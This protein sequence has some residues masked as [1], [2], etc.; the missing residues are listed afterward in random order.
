MRSPAYTLGYGLTIVIAGVLLG[1][2][3]AFAVTVAAVVAGGVMV[4]AAGSS[5]RWRGRTPCSCG[6]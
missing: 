6:A 4:V 1:G 5:S 2:R 3:G